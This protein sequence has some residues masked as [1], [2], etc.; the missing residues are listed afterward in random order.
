M[1][2][3]IHRSAT[4]VAVLAALLAACS[5]HV[6]A[7]SGPSTSAG[8]GTTPGTSGSSPTTSGTK[9]IS[10]TS[11]DS[12]FECATV[13]VPVDY[14]HPDG[15]KL[16]IALVKVPASDPSKRIGSLLVNPGGPGGSGI[17]LA[18]GNPWP[19]DIHERFD[20]VGFDPRGV[21]R[22][23][24]LDCHRTLAEMYHSDPTPRTA[25][26]TSHLL[27][28]SRTFVRNCATAYRALLPHLGT[29]D[30]A[31]D[32]DQ[33]RVALGESKLNYL[34]YSYGTS[35]GQVYA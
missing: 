20:V 11:C 35:I 33:I 22:S 1:R 28:E 29:R 6:A 16:S 12:S 25:P 19:S 15:P 8:G 14:A 24:P 23:S 31:R 18:E 9:S 10:W 27:Q 17:D 30:V 4:F 13:Q 5:V 3:S 2:P 21:G 7:N 26:E 34:G 32:L